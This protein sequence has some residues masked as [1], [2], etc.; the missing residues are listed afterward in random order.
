MS[1][2]T[3]PN[4]TSAELAD[5]AGRRDALRQAAELP[6]AD[7]RALLD[8]AF[9]ELDAAVEVLIKLVRADA[10]EPDPAAGS[11]AALSAER[12]LLRAVFQQAPAPLF[13]LEPDGTIRRANNR[14][15]DLIGSAPGYA[16]GKPLT[17]FVDLPS[18]AAVQSQL[19]AATRTGAA[20]QADCT[21]LGPDGPVAATLT[22]SVLTDG[23]R[24]LVVTVAAVPPEGPGGSGGPGG[25]G[26]AGSPPM[27][28]GSPGG[29]P[30]RGR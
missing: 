25:Y 21:L 23:A 14:A 4:G 26:G 30:P 10:A 13:L 20:R 11:P 7:P 17:A 5:L 27:T 28:G 3:W 22:A 29:S 1:Q 9:A 6:G 15:G 24:L 19:A 2:D 12:S 18:R 8:A 16:T